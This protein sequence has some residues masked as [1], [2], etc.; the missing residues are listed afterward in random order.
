MWLF[1]LISEG[2]H[3]IY[4][5]KTVC[6]DEEMQSFVRIS[7]MSFVNND[8]SLKYEKILC[9]GIETNW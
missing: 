6:G 1:S 7:S 3:E 5:H 4:V 9:K 2:E 8:W